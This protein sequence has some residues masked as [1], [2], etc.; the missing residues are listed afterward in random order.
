MLM[1]AY[2]FYLTI[3]VLEF[4]LMATVRYVGLEKLNQIKIVLMV[5]LKTLMFNQGVALLCM[6]T[7]FTTLALAGF[8]VY[9]MGKYI[10]DLT[11]NE[12]VKYER[13]MDHLMNRATKM[14]QGLKTKRSIKNDGLEK[15]SEEIERMQKWMD[16]WEKKQNEQN[17]FVNL[18]KL[19]IK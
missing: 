11:M 9:I 18:F 16:V 4:E 5:L 8:F 15:M 6:W 14:L 7:F 19:L 3:Y 10:R 1:C 17:I 2:K 13:T 12:E